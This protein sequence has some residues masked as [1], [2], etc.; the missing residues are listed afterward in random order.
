MNLLPRTSGIFLF[1][2]LV[3]AFLLATSSSTAHAQN[4]KPPIPLPSPFTPIVDYANVIDAET[5]V[6][7]GNIY[8]NLKEKTKIEFAVVTVDSTGEQ[9]IFDFALALGRCW[10][11]GP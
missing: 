8:K 2:V 11:I 5:E 7:L 6:R 3:C 10:G 1:S 9:D 4:C